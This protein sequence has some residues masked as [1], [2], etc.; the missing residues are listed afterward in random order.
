MRRIVTIILFSVCMVGC[1]HVSS[2]SPED[3][4]TMERRTIL[5]EALSRKD[6]RTE[7]GLAERDLP[8]DVWGT[9]PKYGRFNESRFKREIDLTDKL[10]DGIKPRIQRMTAPELLESLKVFP[11]GASY[12]NFESVVFYVWRDGNKMIMEELKLRPVADL[13]TLRCHTNDLRGV[14][15]DAEG[16]Y[17]TV[18]DVVHRSLGDTHW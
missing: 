4:R 17:L 7:W 3:K 12:A 13:E 15:T 10:L 9:H 2:L 18:G 5:D 14:F 16:E 6:I 11:P 8:T 1:R